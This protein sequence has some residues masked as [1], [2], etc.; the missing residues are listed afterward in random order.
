VE[1][2]DDLEN[3]SIQGLTKVAAY[4]PEMEGQFKGIRSVDYNKIQ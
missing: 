1:Y 4:L 3:R 2:L